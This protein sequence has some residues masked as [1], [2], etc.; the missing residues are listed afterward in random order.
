MS[1]SHFALMDFGKTAGADPLADN[2]TIATYFP[3]VGPKVVVM[4]VYAKVALLF[5]FA[6][7]AAEEKTGR[8][9]AHKN[10]QAT[11]DLYAQLEIISRHAGHCV[12]GAR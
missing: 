3:F 4:T 9:D 2:H 5:T 7:L 8:E 1:K 12:C 6:Q 11:Q 10:Q